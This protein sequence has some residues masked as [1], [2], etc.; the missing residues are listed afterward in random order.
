MRPAIKLF[1]L[2]LTS[3][4]FLLVNSVAPDSRVALALDAWAGA[5]GP[6]GHVS[7]NEPVE[8]VDLLPESTLL[9]VEVRN[10][11]QRWPELR[12]FSAIRRCQDQML[13]ALGLSPDDLLH[14][15]GERTLLAL[16]VSDDDR[17]VMP[18][19]LLRPAHPDEA[20]TVLRAI[21][22]PAGTALT[23]RRGGGALWVA[24]A[25]AS[26]RLDALVARGDR[27][28]QRSPMAARARQRPFGSALIRGWLDPA[29]LRSLLDGR[30]EGAR[31]LPIEIYLDSLAAALD[32]VRFIEFERDVTRDGIVTDGRIEIDPGRLPSV[33]ARVF[34]SAP[35]APPVLPSP[36]PPGVVLAW[37]F[38][39]EADAQWAWL[40]HVAARD[41]R[42]SL[43][44]FDF[45]TDEFE[46]RYARD[47]E[48]DLVQALGQRGWLFLVEGETRGTVQ[49]ALL[50]ETRDAARVEATLLD[51][52]SW[53]VEQTPARTLGLV[54]PRPRERSL[55][56]LGAHGL[57]IRTPLAE[58]PGPAFLVT[59]DCLVLGTGY[60]ALDA[61]LS[62][63]RTRPTWVTTRLEAATGSAP[64]HESI[65]VSGPTLSGW[66][67]AVAGPGE[68]GGSAWLDLLESLDGISV[69]VWY[70][71]DAVRIASEIRFD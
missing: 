36:L 27:G 15:A 25:E 65:R 19:A 52:R 50:L 11:A 51:L 10:L 41:P 37:S 28:S 17:S 59:G 67:E 57:A 53:L 48:R 33:V 34:A 16:V 39:V 9:A 20:E 63:L 30:V 70:E 8:L 44:N 55:N 6:A 31:P 12:A 1:A 66:L 61:G 38:P 18:L 26:A 49:A 29:P 5:L 62:L 47:L 56:E 24:P 13:A 58:L 23:T 21:R 46:A 64:P 40:R 32:A 60:A 14:L 22:H 71:T 3:V 2:V 69:D 4:L 42:G 54:A 7:V 43:R 68:S 45:W 35:E